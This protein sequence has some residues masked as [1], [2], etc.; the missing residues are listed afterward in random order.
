[1]AMLYDYQ[2]VYSWGTVGKGTVV[3]VRIYT[4]E[5]PI[6][7]LTT[8]ATESLLPPVAFLAAEVAARHPDLFPVGMPFVL[9]DHTPADGFIRQADL[10]ERVVFDSYH[11]RHGRLGIPIWYSLPRASFEMLIG[12]SFT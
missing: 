7:V 2:H 11:P 6:L 10:I 9:V 4:G 8:P 5:F 1:M 12:E 3:R